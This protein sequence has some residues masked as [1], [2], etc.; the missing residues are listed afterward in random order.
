MIQLKSLSSMRR[1]LEIK[2]FKIIFDKMHQ[3]KRNTYFV[4]DLKRKQSTNIALI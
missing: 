3:Q 4:S 2:T 1:V